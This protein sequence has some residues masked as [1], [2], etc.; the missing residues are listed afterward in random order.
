MAHGRWRPVVSRLDEL[1]G[2]SPPTKR[3]RTYARE[4][5]AT[6]HRSWSWAEKCGARPADRPKK[7]RAISAEPSRAAI[8]DPLAPQHVHRPKIVAPQ[9]AVAR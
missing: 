6:W 2:R 3:T 5:L 4:P 8:R 1:V 7:V 9:R